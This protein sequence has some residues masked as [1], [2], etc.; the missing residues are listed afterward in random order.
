VRLIQ[1][2][3]DGSTRRAIGG[4]TFVVGD[5]AGFTRRPAVST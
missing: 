4:Q 5:V 1:F 2:A 3:V